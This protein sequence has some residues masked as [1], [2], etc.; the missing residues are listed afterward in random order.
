MDKLLYQKA[1][2][3]LSEYYE[4]HGTYGDCSADSKQRDTDGNCI[5]SEAHFAR[6]SKNLNPSEEDIGIAIEELY[7]GIPQGIFSVWT[8]E[9]MLR[10]IN[11]DSTCTDSYGNV[12]NNE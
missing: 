11:R 1:I 5:L 3:E 6:E 10:E 9:D 4:G 7:G 2:T 8:L 12:C